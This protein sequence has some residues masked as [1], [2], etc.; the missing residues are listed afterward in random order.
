LKK[1]R[2]F[3]FEKEKNTSV[4]HTGTGSSLFQNGYH[5]SALEKFYI[6]KDGL[7]NL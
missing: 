4:S 7:M 5:T 1:K 3:F 6:I 2:I